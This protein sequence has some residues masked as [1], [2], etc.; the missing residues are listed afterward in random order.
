MQGSGSYKRRLQQGRS[1]AGQ[2]PPPHQ[3][4]FCLQ[5]KW[6]HPWHPHLAESSSGEEGQA[7]RGPGALSSAASMLSIYIPLGEPLHLLPNWVAPGSP[8]ESGMEGPEIEPPGMP[9]GGG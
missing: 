4:R 2:A 8:P 5:V 3:G 1:S 9:E 7:C 6:H